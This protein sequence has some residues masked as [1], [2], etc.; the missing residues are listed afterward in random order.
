M[1]SAS[2]GWD[3]I[4]LNRQNTL[5]FVRRVLFSEDLALFYVTEK[6][7]PYKDNVEVGIN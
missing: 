3:F 2:G 7:E 6:A 1:S 5:I 4:I